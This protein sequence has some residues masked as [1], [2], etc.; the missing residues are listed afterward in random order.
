MR[1]DRLQWLP[2][3]WGVVGA[4]TF[5]LVPL[6]HELSFFASVAFVF[7]GGGLLLFIAKLPLT[8]DLESSASLDRRAS[9]TV[10]IE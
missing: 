7:V 10:C 8:C 5:L 4:S 6:R 9:H 1:W 3:L 2:P